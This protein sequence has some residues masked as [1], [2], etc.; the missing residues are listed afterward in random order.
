MSTPT[1]S[2]QKL[3]KIVGNRKLNLPCQ[4][5]I[6]G[7]L[8]VVCLYIVVV[9]G[10]LLRYDSNSE[11]A[12]WEALKRMLLHLRGTCHFNLRFSKSM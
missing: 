11:K 12:H 7:I 3:S 8:Y 9:V 10:V 5:S 6:G 4:E 1:D 2:K